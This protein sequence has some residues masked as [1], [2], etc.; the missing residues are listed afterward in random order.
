MTPR[1]PLPGHS[2]AEHNPELVPEWS[3]KNEYS[4]SEVS[5][6][7]NSK[8][9]WWICPKGHEDYPMYCNSR[10]RGRGCP[11]CGKDRVRESRRKPKIGQS[12]GDIYPEK[13][14][15]WSPSNKKTPFEVCFGTTDTYL[16]IC[17]IH[18]GYEKSCELVGR[19][20]GCGRCRPDK[21]RK[22]R[23]YCDYHSSISFKSPEAKLHWSNS[24]K[25][26]INH[27][28]ANSTI[29]V[30]WL[31]NN[32]KEEY[33][34]P[35]A[36]ELKNKLRWLCVDCYKKSLKGRYQKP[37]SGQS[38][39]D[40]EPEK[41]LEWSD[42][43][44][45]DPQQI[46]RSSDYLAQWICQDCGNIWYSTVNNRAGSSGTGCPHCFKLGRSQTE[47][48]LRNSLTSLGA[49]PTTHKI[50]HWEVDI[51][52]PDSKTVV[53]YDGSAWHHRDINYE[54]DKRKSLELLK[55]GYRVIR[56]RTYG[57]FI[58]DPLQINSPNYFEIFTTEPKNLIPSTALLE[59]IKE[60]LCQKN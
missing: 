45:Y 22:T 53:E 33:S 5:Y 23:M 59:Q 26:D 40:C 42:N 17:P 24:N 39:A 32:C 38:F 56:I 28:Y 1:K 58:L 11:E 16:W 50:G 43:N 8:K 49:L 21:F 34:K 30:I 46:K 37:K 31:C 3:D 48:N 54:R 20:V 6:G 36:Q 51:F 18:G 27:V 60:I 7:S 19:G 10:S 25:L 29:P 14:S 47:N 55:M 44:L 57:N 35:P 13:I 15:I 2:I 41:A 9:F 4:P 12:F 52:F